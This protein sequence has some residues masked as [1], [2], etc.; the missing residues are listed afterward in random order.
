MLAVKSSAASVSDKVKHRLEQL[1]DFDEDPVRQM[2]NLTQQDYIMKIEQLNHQLRDAW[3]TDQRVKALKITIQ[4]AK[5]LSDT[6]AMQF[7]PSKFVLITD[8]LDLFG[9][10]VYDRLRNK[11]KY[12]RFVNLNEFKRADLPHFFFLNTY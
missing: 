7:Y 6:S 3:N 5:L 12:I 11:S 2:H 10:L 8:I 1:D 9:K 4:C